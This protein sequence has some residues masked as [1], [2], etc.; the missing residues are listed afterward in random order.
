[1]Y[2]ISNERLSWIEA[3]RFLLGRMVQELTLRQSRYAGAPFQGVNHGSIMGKI[4]EEQLLLN[5]EQNCIE[6]YLGSEKVQTAKSED[7][8]SH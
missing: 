8:K 6:E 1:M 5:I 2:P 3:R 4:R 7:P